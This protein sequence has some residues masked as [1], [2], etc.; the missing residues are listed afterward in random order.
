VHMEL[1]QCHASMSLKSLPHN[2]SA[3]TFVQFLAH[4][5]HICVEF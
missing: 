3:P 4:S 2:T 1:V 5:D